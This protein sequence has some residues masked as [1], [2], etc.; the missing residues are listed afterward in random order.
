[1]AFD[2]VSGSLSITALI[3]VIVMSVTIYLNAQAT[4]KLISLQIDDLIHQIN[5]GH[6]FLYGIINTHETMLNNLKAR[7]SC[8]N[9][10][11]Q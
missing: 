8:V 1:M 3:I 11:P 10:P 5:S 7:T 4:K 9:C 6:S 2:F